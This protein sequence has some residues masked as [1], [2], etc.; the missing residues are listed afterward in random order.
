MNLWEHDIVGAY[1][2][3]NGPGIHDKSQGSRM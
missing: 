3:D 1:E 2:L